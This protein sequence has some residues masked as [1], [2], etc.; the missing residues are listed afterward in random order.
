MISC[1][2]KYLKTSLYK[3]L[4]TNINNIC[5]KYP[6]ILQKP[7]RKFLRVKRNKEV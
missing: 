5:H 1:D 6:I 4:Q 7:Q 2:S 3:D